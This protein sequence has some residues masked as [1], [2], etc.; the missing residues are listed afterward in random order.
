MTDLPDPSSGCEMRGRARYDLHVQT[1]S[2]HCRARRMT[3]VRRPLKYKLSRLG[4]CLLYGTLCRT[5]AI[6]ASRPMLVVQRCRERTPTK[7]LEPAR[8]ELHQ[9]PSD[10]EGARSGSAVGLK[11]GAAGP[12]GLKLGSSMDGRDGKACRRGSDRSRSKQHSSAEL[13]SSNAAGVLR[14]KAQGYEPYGTSKGRGP[15]RKGRRHTSGP[16]AR[17]GLVSAPFACQ[18][19]GWLVGRSGRHAKKP[20][21]PPPAPNP[22]PTNL[23]ACPD[24]CRQ[25]KYDVN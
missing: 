5:S 4:L 19:D 2:G 10:Q 16:S 22:G 15:G 14:S 6:K 23:Q 24:A 17:L 25:L 1:T 13:K 7:C 21:P 12:V 3:W 9:S 8:P 20:A 18:P 11:L